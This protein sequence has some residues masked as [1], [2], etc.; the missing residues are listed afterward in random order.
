MGIR[1]SAYSQVRL[2]AAITL[3][4]KAA[5]ARILTTG[6]WDSVQRNPVTPA[7]A[8]DTSKMPA[9][10]PE[11]F[12]RSE[13]QNTSP[14]VALPLASPSTIFTYLPVSVCLT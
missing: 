4:R 1:G 7:R 9:S 2:K 5:A 14:G 12:F 10:T 13:L 8:S 11:K 6:A 3:T